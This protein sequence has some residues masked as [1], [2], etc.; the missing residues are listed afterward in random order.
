MDRT[1][2]IPGID[3]A[4][5]VSSDQEKVRILTVEF[6]SKSKSKSKSKSESGSNSGKY[7]LYTILI[8]KPQNYIPM[9]HLMWRSMV[10]H[11]GLD[12]AQ[13]EL[14][15][16]GN[17]KCLEEV[18]ASRKRKL[19]G[20]RHVHALE[21]PEEPDLHD[22]L[23][24]KL[25]IVDFLASA[26]APSS[27][28]PN[29]KTP[30]TNYDQ[31]LYMDCDIIV[32]APIQKL[33]DK[34]VLRPGVLHAAREHEDWNHTFFGFANYS[35]EDKA[36]FKKLKAVT[37]NDGTFMFE[38]TPEML[39]HLAKIRAFARS[40]PDLRKKFYDQS[41][42]NDYFNRI[43]K[44]DTTVLGKAVVIFPKK[45]RAYSRATFVHFAG[46]GGYEGKLARMQDYVKATGL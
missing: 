25:D 39:G 38:P 41:F 34:A 14:L 27:T 33:V 6:M 9:F 22:A 4:K 2:R 11:G 21:V 44:A 20:V 28:T 46:L 35:A 10:T 7:L 40:R 12:P 36:L 42:F 18:A 19:P 23:L 43:G 29:T 5:S 26:S 31:V 30:K 13:W 17:K 1:S 3:L 16:I 37:F 32:R 8:G 15:I 45:G 24:R